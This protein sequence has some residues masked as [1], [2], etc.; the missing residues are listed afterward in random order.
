MPVTTILIL[1][2]DSVKKAVLVVFRQFH[3]VF[4]FLLL[5]QKTPHIFLSLS[6]RLSTNLALVGFRPYL[7]SQMFC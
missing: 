4:E 6:S 1:E 3:M 7:S 5:Y 2:P